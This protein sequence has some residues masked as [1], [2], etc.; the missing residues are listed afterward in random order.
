M[1]VWLQPFTVIFT[2]LFGDNLTNDRRIRRPLFLTDSDSENRFRFR[3]I[4]KRRRAQAQQN[5]NG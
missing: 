4:T 1:E 2:F 5:A 3:H